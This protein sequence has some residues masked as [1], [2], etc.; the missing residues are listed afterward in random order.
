MLASVSLECG[1]SHGTFGE[2]KK[3]KIRNHQMSHNKYWQD[4][5]PP[6]VVRTRTIPEGYVVVNGENLYSNRKWPRAITSAQI[7][8]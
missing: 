6:V 4:L 2:E 5:L 7:L 8:K 1:F 3:K